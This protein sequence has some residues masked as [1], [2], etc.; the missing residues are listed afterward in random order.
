MKGLSKFLTFD[1]PLFAKD[2]NFMSIRVLNWTN[3]DN[4]QILGAKVEALITDDRTDYGTPELSQT[5]L[6]EKVVFKVPHQINIPAQIEVRPKGNVRA[7]VYGEY[8]NQL[9]VTV[10]DI[11]IVEA[12][13]T[14]K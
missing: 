1:W 4:G 11:E 8:R 12:S 2:K 7:V 14:K 9:S 5:N 3:P 6:Y 13:N 10:D